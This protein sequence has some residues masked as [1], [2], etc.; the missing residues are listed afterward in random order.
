MKTMQNYNAMQKNIYISNY[1]S[2]INLGEIN[3][4]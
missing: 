2:V 3:W 4:K 1:L